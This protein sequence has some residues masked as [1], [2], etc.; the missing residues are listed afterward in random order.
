MA[1]T[2]QYATFTFVNTR[3]HTITVDAYISDV[4]AALVT[5]GIGGGSSSSSPTEWK[6]PEACYLRDVIIVTGLADTTK[7]QVNRNNNA[8]GDILRYALFDDG[9][10][11]R[12]PLNIPFNRGDMLTCTQLA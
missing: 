1:A 10:A 7:L 4:A 11:T 2:P 3:G 6:A 9:L 5:F 12:G 8:T